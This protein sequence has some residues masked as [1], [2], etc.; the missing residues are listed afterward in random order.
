MLNINYIQ[1]VSTTNFVA[2]PL[3]TAGRP[4]TFK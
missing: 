4:F 3:G 2:V 1:V